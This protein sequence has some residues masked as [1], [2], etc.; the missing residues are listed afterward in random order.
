MRQI[1]ERQ[2]VVNYK[3]NLNRKVSDVGWV[4]DYRG[5]GRIERLPN[6]FNSVSIS[7]KYRLKFGG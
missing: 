5:E 6:V 7:N 4:D 3:W 1:V 2:D